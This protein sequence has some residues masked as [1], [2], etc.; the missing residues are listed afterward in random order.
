MLSIRKRVTNFFGQNKYVHSVYV[1][2][3]I[4]VLLFSPVVSAQSW[5]WYTGGNPPAGYLANPGNNAGG[6]EHMLTGAIS[7]D[8]DTTTPGEYCNYYNTGTV[9]NHQ[10]NLDQSS[11]TGFNPGLPYADWQ[12]GDS[13]SYN[14]CQAKGNTFGFKVTGSANSNC[15]GVTIPA[16]CGMHQY[17]RLSGGQDNRPWSDSF[18]ISPAPAL[19]F[20]LHV[21]PQTAAYTGGVFGYFCPHLQDVTT[22]NYIEYCFV[23]WQKGSG[24][25]AISQYDQLGDCA[26]TPSG[27]NVDT[28]FT[29]FHKDMNWSTQRAGSADTFGAVPNDVYMSASISAQNIRNVINLINQPGPKPNGCNRGLSTD[30]RNYALIGFEHG[31]EGGNFSALGASVRNVNIHTTTD[32]LYPGD[33]LN[34]N[35]SMYSSSGGYRLVMQGDG[36]LVTYSSNNTP[37]WSSQ[38]FSPGAYLIMQ[39]DGNLVIYNANGSP[40]WNSPVNYVGGS[41][42]VMQTDGNFVVYKG[43]QPKWSSW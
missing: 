35:Q 6:L 24:F 15:N 7:A 43:S 32:T 11:V 16:P 25:P 8:L 41:Y 21:K 4:L 27:K 17:V 2:S 3:S 42:A 1:L 29:A 28:I 40:I 14:V 36:N 26:T 34:P 12:E 20:S 31:V 18:G 10:N 39:N 23:E 33:R 22:G 19:T 13:N 37:V 9:L 38:T 5:S 30:I